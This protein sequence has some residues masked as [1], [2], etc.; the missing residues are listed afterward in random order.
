MWDV[1][2]S[3]ASEDKDEIARPLADALVN[4]GFRVWFDDFALKLGDSLSGSIN[5][6]LAQ[7]RYG[8]VILSPAFFAKE[9]PQ[10][11]LNGLN[12]REISGGKVILPV[13]HQVDRA[14]VAR[15]SPILADKLGVSTER[16]LAVVVHDVLQ[17]LK[18][19][20][21]LSQPKPP[22]SRITKRTKVLVAF[23]G[24]GILAGGGWIYWDVAGP[25]YAR[26]R[27]E[28]WPMEYSTTQFVERAGQG[29]LAAVKLF[30]AAGIDPN[31]AEDDT[32]LMAAA[33]EGRIEVMQA[34][35]NGGA[36]VNK[37]SKG[38]HP[39]MAAAAGGQSAAVRML[40]EKGVEPDAVDRAVVA[41]AEGGNSELLQL[42]Y[43]HGASVSVEDG[44]SAL[45]EAAYHGHTALAEILLDHGVDV[46]GKDQYSDGFTA[47][48][49][50]ARDDRIETI[51]L[52]LKRGAAI[53]SRDKDGMTALMWVVTHPETAKFLVDQGAD[54]RAR[55]NQGASVLH[56]ALRQ[57]PSGS[58]NTSEPLVDR[59]LAKGVDIDLATDSG[60]TPLMAAAS[61]PQSASTINDLLD[62][63]A[64]IN[65]KNQR[66]YTALM[67]ALQRTFYY[68]PTMAQSVDTL[69]KRG[70][71]VSV[72]AE[73]GETAISLSKQLPA[74]Y[75]K[76]F[77]K[78]LQ[79]KRRI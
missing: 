13:W 52:L 71:D 61:A 17:V 66:G 2:I 30:L 67:L 11:E 1:F 56:H 32:A 9:W 26:A 22:K 8:I 15:F 63:G 12:S 34:L 33:R 57:I 49:T 23:C 6:G 10:R 77:A 44:I 20:P 45:R 60:E 65:A 3:H 78:L 68:Y 37:W 54:V 76:T 42:L 64:K 62:R 40:L 51:R 43:D 31:Q 73:D 36:K 16:G 35:L 24:L 58:A 50:A 7:A 48:T 46:N 41:A 79:S 25:A 5:H 14:D 18:D 55:D 47:L 39:L 21:A 28:A 75:Q 29:D 27:L 19:Q 74:E 4:A 69:V 72:V 59:L 38:Y 70:A 53:D